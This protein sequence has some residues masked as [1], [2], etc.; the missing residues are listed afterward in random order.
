MEV[1]AKYTITRKLE[2]AALET[3]DLRPYRL[4]LASEEQHHDTVLDTPDRALTSHQQ[5]LRARHVNGHITVTYKGPDIGSGAL[6]ER[7]ELEATFAGPLPK[8]YRAWL[9]QITQRVE[10][11]VGKAV[12]VPLV[13]MDVHRRTWNLLRRTQVVAELALDEGVIC[14]SGKTIPVREL[15]IELK[16]TG[17]RDDLTALEELFSRQLSLRP[18]PHSKLERGLALLQRRTRKEESHRSLEEASREKLQGYLQDL[19]T[20]EPVARAGVDPEGV[21]KMRVAI[22]R[23]R[24][25]LKMLQETANAPKQQL[26]QLRRELSVLAR[27]LGEVRDLDVLLARV[28]AYGEQEPAIGDDLAMLREH[29]LNLRTAASRRLRARLASAKV[30]DTLRRLEAYVQSPVEPHDGDDEHP[31]MLVRHV[32]GGAIWTRY[33]RLLS[34]ETA[35]RDASPSVLH[36]VRIACKQT[37]YA[38]EF[39]APA[40]GK[41]AKPLLK[42]LIQAQDQLGNQHDA[43]VLL[44]YTLPLCDLYPEHLGLTR[45]ATALAAERD[46]LQ[47]EFAPLWEDLAGKHFQ[48]VLARLLGHL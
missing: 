31:V 19:R 9:P 22:R 2:P 42:T 18:E 11:L 23:L 4:R 32:A 15:E 35:M 5:E 21:H 38:M 40:L 3:L 25:A 34:Y 8:D 36:Q 16:E 1:E 47:A 44:E 27:A 12:L 17:T 39:S 13:E 37:R 14:A 46:H 10:P 7:E 20:F 29:L 48:K 45:Y 43:V 26:R 33:E 28:Q 41:R 30:A 6:H 24:T